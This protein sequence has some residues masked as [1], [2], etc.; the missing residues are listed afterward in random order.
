MGILFR[1]PPT[2]AGDGYFAG[3]SNLL[4]LFAFSTETVTNVGSLT[5]TRTAAAG[6]NSATTGYLAGGISAG[7][8]ASIS[9]IAFSNNSQSTIS[10]VLS[11]ARYN[12]TGVNSS[13][14]GYAMT[15]QTSASQTT[16][17]TAIDGIQFDTEAAIDPGAAVSPAR[18]YSTG[19]NSSTVG[20]VG[21][22]RNSAGS[23]MSDID[24]FTFTSETTYGVTATLTLM[25]G[26]SGFNSS[27]TGYFAGGQTNSSSLSAIIQKLDFTAETTSTLAATLQIAR[28]TG[29]AVNSTTRGY[30]GGGLV[31]AVGSSEI[32]GIQF[33]TEAAINPSAV[34][35]AAVYT[36]MGVQSGS[37]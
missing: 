13:T 30:V 21:G 33:N 31:G 20:Y 14:R 7:G 23:K 25:D 10:A 26:M 29:A 24:G 19:V 1:V 8:S 3:G 15:G 36:I 2:P 12:T 6:F 27:S 18:S 22:G 16:V 17:T 4:N 11:V 32:D 35:T 9:S 37:L 5:P 28:T 34:L